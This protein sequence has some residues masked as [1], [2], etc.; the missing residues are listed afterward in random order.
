MSGDS[1][2][3]DLVGLFF[4]MGGHLGAV[5]GEIVGAAQG[6]YL[7]RREGA[8][9]LELMELDDL[10]SARFF[11]PADWSKAGHTIAGQ[12][13]DSGAANAA[14][15]LMARVGDAVPTTA[16][17]TSQNV[18]AQD[19]GATAKPTEPPKRRFLDQIKRR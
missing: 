1:Q 7:V 15:S 19:A 3:D 17:A 8:A 18:S 9:H 2:R 13:S 14:P 5:S 6:L 10:R 16:D 4:H 12:A 11:T